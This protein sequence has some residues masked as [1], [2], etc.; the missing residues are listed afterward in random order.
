MDLRYALRTLR[1]SPGFTATAILTLALGIGSSVAI[2]TLLDQVSFRLLPVKDPERLVLLQWDGQ[3]PGSTNGYATWSYPWY[4]DLRDQSGE[5]FEDVFGRFGIEMAVGHSGETEQT[6]V[7]LV[8]GNYFRALGIGAGRGRVLV[9]ADDQQPGAHPV[10]VLSYEFWRDRF[11]SD[12]D[13]VGQTIRINQ[14]PFEVVGVVQRGFRGMEFDFTPRVFIPV[15]MKD[16]VSAGFHKELYYLENRR[17]RWLNVF[18]RLSDGVS[19]EQAQARLEPLMR[20]GLEYDI[21]QPQLSFMD[22]YGRAR[23]REARAEVAPGGQGR[24]Y[25]RERLDSPLLML[26]AMVGLLLLIACGNVANLLMA[27]AA[28]RAK[29][30]AVRFALGAGRARIVRQ[31]MME[32]AVLAVASCALGL[33]FAGWAAGLVVQF[34]PDGPA[35]FNLST[36]PDW[37]IAGFAAAVSA[38][39]AFVFGLAPALRTTRLHLAPT[40]KDQAGAI[41]GGNDVWRRAL[42]TSQIFFSLL[43]LVGAGLFVRSL[44]HLR[45]LETGMETE[46][47]LVFGLDPMQGGYTVERLHPFLSQLEQELAARPEVESSGFSSVRVL[48]NDDWSNSVRVEGYQPARDENMNPH[49]NAVSPGYFATLDIPL[50]E[51]RA[52]T[53]ADR[54]GA[55]K[56]GIVNETFAERYFKGQSA[57]GRHFGF[58]GDTDIEIVGVIPDVRYQDMRQEIPRQVFVPFAQSPWP[59]AAHVYVRTQR[60]PENAAPAV[61]AVVR[62][63]DA[64]LPVYD[65]RLMEAQVESTLTAERLLAFLATAFGVLA[66]ILAAVG[67]YGLLAYSVSRRKREIGLR[68]ALG[69]QRSDVAWLVLKEVVLLFAIAAGAAVPAALALGQLTQSQLHGVEAADPL[70]MALAAGIL[71][72]VALAAGYLPARRAARIEPM[73]ALRSE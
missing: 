9:P 41:A 45:G 37:R 34:A 25:V 20:A 59:T 22:E 7:E 54:N 17:G 27:R 11:G 48:A 63:M 33:A 29:E 4:Q 6:E 69:A 44:S 38:L 47:T 5:T 14:H 53:E 28:G 23:Y 12:P 39:T 18:G 19:R 56:V 8:T 57:I 62:R 50:L 71:A 10:A 15:M 64:G 60:D 67:L 21:A 24:R 52:F 72:A 73:E 49:Y 42:A 32:S 36:T 51:G 16:V 35:S 1:K 2:F 3:W 31:L 68:V 26:M 13:A 70:N 61:R 43:L 66:T 30:V 58:S 55:P 65:L 46:H 40:L